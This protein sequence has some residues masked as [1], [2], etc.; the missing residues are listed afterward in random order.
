MEYRTLG[1]S[2]LR[3][4]AISIGGWRTFGQ[5]VDDAGTEACMKTAY[6]AG[7]NYFDG[8]EAYGRG[9]AEEA[10]GRVLRK[11]KWPRDTL[12]LSGKVGPWADPNL[13][14]TQYGLNRKH[15]VECCDQTMQRYGVDY[16]D[17]FFC[18]RPDPATPLEEIVE[19]MTELIRRGKIFYWGTSQFDPADLMRLHAIARERGLIGPLMEQTHFHLF[20]PHRLTRDL[21]PLFEHYGMG[22][23][24]F[25]PLAGGILTGKYNDG[26]PTGSRIATATED[27]LKRS[28]TDERLAA[29]R[30]LGGLAGE[31]GM[32][33]AELS[34]AWVLK[35]PRVDTAIM[36]AT[37][38]EQV[39]MNVKA[40]ETAK[41]LTDEVMAHIG[42]IVGS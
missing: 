5:S 40:V 35:H 3:V 30:A 26:I 9:A 20:D 42:E 7:I 16:L 10:M 1:K 32:T 8:A 18:H 31:L 39:E 6:E 27:W 41:K 14:A 38:P 15:L 24:V 25:S 37:R 33:Q 29:S 13:K 17:L 28:L 19:T 34:L 12:V 36:G 4:S 23:T 11:M 22:T 21:V 2:G